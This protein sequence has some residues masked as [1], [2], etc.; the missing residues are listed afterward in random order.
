M[1]RVPKGPYKTSIRPKTNNVPGIFFDPDTLQR[2]G[3]PTMLLNSDA[4]NGSAEL[5][6]CF[7]DGNCIAIFSTFLSSAS[8]DEQLWRFVERTKFW[9]TEIWVF[10]IHLQDEK[11]WALATAY[12]GRTTLDVFDS[13][14]VRRIEEKVEN[15][16]LNLYFRY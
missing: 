5:L 15:V 4:I 16:R 7:Y 2:L 6:R 11:H 14:G 13:L 3:G 10:P 8:N 1:K 12:N 9:D